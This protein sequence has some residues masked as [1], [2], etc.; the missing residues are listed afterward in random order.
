MAVSVTSAVAGVDL[1]NLTSGSWSHTVPSGS[2]RYLFVMIAGWDGESNPTAITVTYGGVN[3]P[4]L[5]GCQNTAQN[6]TVIFG[7]VA[8]AVGTANVVVSNI[9]A[10]YNQLACGSISLAGVDQTTPVGT[11]VNG[12]DVNTCT[13]T[14]VASGDLV[15]DCFYDGDS[16]NP[17]PS[18]SGAT[19]HYGLIT[20]GTPFTAYHVASSRGGSGSISPTYSTIADATISAIRVRQS[21][22]AFTG[23]LQAQS[24]STSGKANAFRVS[25]GI[26]AP[27]AT[28]SASIKF[29]GS[30]S[31]AGS[32]GPA[33]VAGVFQAKAQFTGALQTSGGNVSGA[34]EPE[35]IYVEGLPQSQN[36]LVNG[37]VTVIVPRPGRQD[38][39]QAGFYGYR[40]RFG[41]K[42]TRLG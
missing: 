34:Y 36:G 14:G 35:Y 33:T 31:G 17:S 37:A 29:G 2:N 28:L 15:V 41:I 19:K 39:V 7:L 18:D 23:T 8:P 38:E 42:V 10:S 1:H 26:S 5:G 40:R 30:F 16:E 25:S 9:P 4:K 22:L 24:A 11:V 12:Q 20:A 27:S 6:N 13:V 32:A 21:P 3:V